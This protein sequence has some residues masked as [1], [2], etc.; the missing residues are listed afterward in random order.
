MPKDIKVKEGETAK[1]VC[2]GKGRPVPKISWMGAKKAKLPANFK[3]EK[4]TLIVEKAVQSNAG[5]YSCVLSNG[6]GI[7]STSFNIVVE[8]K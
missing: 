3:E 6:M 2:K 8:S 7:N 1:T 4:N 5:E